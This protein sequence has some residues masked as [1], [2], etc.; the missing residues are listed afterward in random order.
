MTFQALEIAYTTMT[1][2][3]IIGAIFL[4]WLDRQ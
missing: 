2:L 1:C 4:V 3:A